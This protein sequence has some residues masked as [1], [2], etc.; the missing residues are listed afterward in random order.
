MNDHPSSTA[1]S[2][3]PGFHGDIELND[4]HM[5][6]VYVLMPGIICAYSAHDQTLDHPDGSPPR[7]AVRGSVRLLDAAGHIFR[8]Q[9]TPTLTAAA[10]KGEAA[11]AEDSTP[12]KSARYRPQQKAVNIPSKDGKVICATIVEKAQALVEENAAYIFSEIDKAKP[13]SQ[14]CLA[15]LFR[16]QLRRYF[17]MLAE[18]GVAISEEARHDRELRIKKIASGPVGLRP[19]GEITASELKQVSKEIGKNW[20]DYFK[21]VADFVDF[22]YL[23][24]HDSNPINA[25]RDYLNAHPERKQMNAKKLQKDAANSDVLI[26]EMDRRFYEDVMANVA[27]GGM[28]GAAIVRS[29]G[30]NAKQACDLKWEQVRWLDEDHTQALIL[31]SQPDKAGRVQNYNFVLSPCWS[32]V[33]RLREQWLLK[34]SY[35]PGENSEYVAS[36]IKDSAKKLQPKELT[37]ICRELAHRYGMSYATLAGLKELENGAGIRVFQA[38]RRYSLEESGMKR[39]PGLLR[40]YLHDSLANNTQANN[41]RNLSGELAQHLATVYLMRADLAL[42][43]AVPN[44][45]RIIRTP[46][47]DGKVVIIRPPDTHS[48]AQGTITPQL[49]QGDVIQISGPNGVRVCV[50]ALPETI[51]SEQL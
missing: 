49:K 9:A 22:L 40:F 39:D 20:R 21:E 32:S 38:T 31:F 10:P 8:S 16:L 25:F 19:L 23:R 13:V 34:N 15:L 43:D 30:F 6:G 4:G 50:K 26:P 14:M 29:T 24:K 48:K 27:D 3:E 36:S 45:D 28:I 17:S 46:N 2:T 11:H 35:H 1:I 7:Y 33:F 47:A 41:Y 5:S 18:R 37:A 12:P 44:A 42:T 51:P